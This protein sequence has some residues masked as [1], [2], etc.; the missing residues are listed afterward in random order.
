MLYRPTEVVSGGFFIKKEKKKEGIHSERTFIAT[1]TQKCTERLFFCC[2]PQR[3]FYSEKKA[4]KKKKKVF[5][6]N[7]SF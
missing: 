3:Q 7:S 2:L 6:S 1:R 4:K 5:D